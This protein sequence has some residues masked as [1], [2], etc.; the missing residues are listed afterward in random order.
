MNNKVPLPFPPPL[1]RT[2][3]A[4]Y[5]DPYTH[6]L[7]DI[8]PNSRH[9]SSKEKR[10]REQAILRDLPNSGYAEGIRERLKAEA[11]EKSAAE[12]RLG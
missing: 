9:C 12:F 2:L 8:D 7:T 6:M 11:D 4:K 10:D 3:S 5:T 1:Y